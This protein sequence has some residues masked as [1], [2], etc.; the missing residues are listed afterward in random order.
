MKPFVVRTLL[1]IDFLSAIPVFVALI[2]VS[3]ER[4]AATLAASGETIR[5]RIRQHSGDPK[6]RGHGA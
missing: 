6:R 3:P 2:F 5:A 1:L 4:Y